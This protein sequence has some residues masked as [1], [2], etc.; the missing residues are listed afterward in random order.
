MN[1]LQKTASLTG[2]GG[3]ELSAFGR[4]GLFGLAALA[5]GFLGACLKGGKTQGQA[6]AAPQ[7]PQNG[8]QETQSSDAE[9]VK[10]AVEALGGGQGSRPGQSCG[11]GPNYPCGTRYYTVSPGDLA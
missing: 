4:A 10:K 6:P 8:V 2:L 11:P 3:R 7:Q 9:T 1:K 5:L